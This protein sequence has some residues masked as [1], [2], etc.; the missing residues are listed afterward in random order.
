MLSDRCP[1]L[2][3]CRVG[4]LWPNGWMDQDETWHGDSPRPQPYCIRWG[5]QFPSPRQGT[6]PPNFWPMSVVAKR[7]DGSRIKMPLG[8][9]VGIGPGHTVLD[10]DPAPP[11]KKHSSPSPI[12]GPCL[13]GPNSR[14]SQLV[15]SSCYN[16]QHKRY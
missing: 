13:L 9:E 1:V 15:R 4:V 11:R 5:T 3:V 14:P 8:T 7:L 10:G 12:F 16:F 2:S 6:T